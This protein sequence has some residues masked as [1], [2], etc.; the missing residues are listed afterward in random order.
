VLYGGTFSKVLF[1]ALGLGYLVVP[2]ILID[3]FER[4][5]RSFLRGTSGLEQAVVARFMQEGHFARHLKRMRSL[6]AAR[7]SALTEALTAVFGD[8]LQLEP[9]SGGTHIIARPAADA[10]DAELV[11]LARER[12]LMPDALSRHTIEH[13]CGQGLLLAFTN[14]PEAQAPAMAQ[15][16]FEAIRGRL[17][18]DESGGRGTRPAGPTTAANLY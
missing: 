7:R 3:T 6:Y 8:R 18:R 16:L 9:S 14:I 2:A 12:G 10:S 1:P 11:L 4:A 5:C 13:D 17:R 15:T